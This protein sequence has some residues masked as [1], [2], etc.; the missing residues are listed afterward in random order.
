MSEES[1]KLLEN[2]MS[3]LGDNPSET[4]GQMLSALSDSDKNQNSDTHQESEQSESAGFDFDML[5]KLQGLMGAFS[6][7]ENDERSTLLCALKPF[8]S[9]EK[10]P[11]VDRAIKL[12]KLSTLAKTAQEMDLLKNLL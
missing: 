2:L 11:Q 7:T 12:L 9:E 1:N 3:A 4:L 10:R 5:M 6:S 8:L